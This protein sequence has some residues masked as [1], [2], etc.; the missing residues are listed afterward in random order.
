MAPPTLIRIERAGAPNPQFP[1]V[2]DCEVW[3]YLNKAHIEAVIVSPGAN[4]DSEQGARIRMTSG[5]EV[6][7]DILE[8]RWLLDQCEEIPLGTTRSDQ[9]LS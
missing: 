5:K 8:A 3:Q 1:N 6:E 2:W 4:D 7:V 9:G